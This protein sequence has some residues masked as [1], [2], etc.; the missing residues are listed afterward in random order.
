MISY[1]WELN[2]WSIILQIWDNFYVISLQVLL[3]TENTRKASQDSR[4][5]TLRILAYSKPEA[6]LELWYI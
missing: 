5:P 6:Y 1:N 4:P 3:K 2:S